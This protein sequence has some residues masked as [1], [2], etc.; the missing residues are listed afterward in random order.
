MNQKMYYN[1]TTVK[2]FQTL[3]CLH[4]FVVVTAKA[5]NLVYYNTQPHPAVELTHSD[6]SCQ[7]VQ[8][9]LPL[10]INCRNYSGFYSLETLN[11][12]E[13]LNSFASTNKLSRSSCIPIDLMQLCLATIPRLI[14][15]INQHASTGS[16]KLPSQQRQKKLSCFELDTIFNIYIFRLQHQKLG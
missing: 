7:A 14:F 4:V 9:S 13:K 8:I 12:F 5:K 3:I 2:I 10:Y 6:Q 1:Y 16:V 15:K 11:F